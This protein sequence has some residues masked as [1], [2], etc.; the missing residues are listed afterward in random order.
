MMDKS[1]LETAENGMSSNVKKT[2]GR[3]IESTGLKDKH[4]I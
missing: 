1:G 2:N 3:I 4:L